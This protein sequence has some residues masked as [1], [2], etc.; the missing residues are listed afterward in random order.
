MILRRAVRAIES[1]LPSQGGQL[2]PPEKFSLDPGQRQG[3]RRRNFLFSF[4]STSSLFREG[5][6]YANVLS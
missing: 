1:G 6:E 3:A 5:S 2:M 4:N